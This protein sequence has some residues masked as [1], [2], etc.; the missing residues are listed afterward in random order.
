MSGALLHRRT[1]SDVVHSKAQGNFT[2]TRTGGLQSLVLA[3]VL[4]R[5]LSFV[6]RRY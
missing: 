6:A 2:F 5:Y 4:G 1:S 3:A